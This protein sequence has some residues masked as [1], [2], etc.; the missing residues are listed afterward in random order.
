[1]H[2]ISPNIPEYTKNKHIFVQKANGFHKNGPIFDVTPPLK[3]SHRT[4][5]VSA[6]VEVHDALI[7]MNTVI[8]L[9]RSPSQLLM[10]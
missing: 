3:S 7:R 10:C 2:Q 1:M 9:L 5:L 6:I 4:V 8:K